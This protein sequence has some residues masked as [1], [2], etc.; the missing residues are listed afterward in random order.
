MSNKKIVNQS[1]PNES[2]E[3]DLNDED[4]ID[5]MRHISGYL[6]IST[7]DFRDIYHLAH[8][9]ALGRIFESFRAKTLIR[10]DIEPLRPDMYLDEAAK[11]IIH[12]GLKGLPVVDDHGGVIGMLTETDYLKHLNADTF[13]ELLLGMLGEDFELKHRCHVTHVSEAMTSPAVTVSLDAGF[14]EVIGAFHRHEG[15]STPV[16]DSDGNLLGMLLRKDFFSS[17]NLEGTK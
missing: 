5:A 16:V 1:D 10:K 6:D 14:Q 3:I 15:R 17:F 2:A 7:E 12:S 4:I 8:R 11:V 9:H 13:L